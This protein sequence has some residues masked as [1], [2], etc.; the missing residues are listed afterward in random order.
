MSTKAQEKSSISAKIVR[1]SV[2]AVVLAMV[3]YHIVIVWKPLFGSQTNQNNHLG[4]C[5]VLL[6]LH[7]AIIDDR[8]W[9]KIIFLTCIPLG[10]CLLTFMEAENVRLMMEVGFPENK[11]I[12]VG[13]LLIILVIAGAWKA[14]G[15]IFPSWSWLHW[16]I[17]SGDTSYPGCSITPNSSSAT[18]YQI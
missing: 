14:F 13:V 2:I 12:I 7:W 4:F 17:R 3:A 6:F 9:V 15:F 8:R 5:F 11:D 18:W 1:W 16:P 10:L